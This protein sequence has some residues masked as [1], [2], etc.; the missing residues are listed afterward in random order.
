MQTS[1]ARDAYPVQAAPTAP[2]SPTSRNVPATTSTATPGPS[3]GATP[4][5]GPHPDAGCEHA[6]LLVTLER[7]ELAGA[8]CTL[9]DVVREL[10]RAGSGAVAGP[11]VVALLDAYHRHLCSA[12][13]ACPRDGEAPVLAFSSFARTAR[14][15]AR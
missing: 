13:R 14:R 4:T 3:P 11:D 8:A 7:A 15:G 9:G 6:S 10:R 12:Y 5:A 1:R 2:A